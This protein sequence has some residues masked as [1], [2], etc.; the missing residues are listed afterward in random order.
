M[1]YNS[2]MI[3]R[4]PLSLSL[5]GLSREGPWGEGARSEIAWASSAGFRAIQ[6]DA[7]MPGI[8][9]R[10]LDRSARRDLAAILRR[11]EL[12]LSG[13]DLWI[14]P[15]HF[16]SSSLVARAVEAAIQAIGLAAELSTL[17]G[18]SSTPVVSVLLPG[19]LPADVLQ[20]LAD[21]ALRASAEIADHAAEPRH[22]PLP[23]R[24]GID[25]AALLLA[26]VDVISTTSKAGSNLA[27]ARLSDASLAGRTAPL[28]PAG[29]LDAPAYAAA[30]SVVAYSRPVVLDLRG[31]AEQPAAAARALERW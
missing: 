30:L 22:G 15:E 18:G 3:P 31:V 29:R 4:P 11:S 25:P 7:T 20:S 8:R 17:A 10:E 16:L 14:P 19:E 24:I 6:L 26:G 9:P 5:S 28:S 21:A 23:L 13:L 2:A 1:G 12:T 27:S